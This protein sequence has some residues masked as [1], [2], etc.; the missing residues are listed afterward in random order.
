ME[1]EGSDEYIIFDAGTGLRDFGNHI[2]GQ[3]LRSSVFHIF[4]SHLHWDHIQGFPFFIPAFLKQNRIHIYGCHNGLKDA[5]VSQQSPPF[6]PVPFKVMNA[7]ID[8]SILTPLK[9]YEIAGIKVSAIEQNHPGGSYAYRVEKNGK[10]VV[11]AS[12]SE[13]KELGSSDN[14]FLDF[15]KG[16]DLLIFDA[17]YSL[18]DSLHTKENWGHSSNIAAVEV[19]L[20]AGVKHVCLFHS[21]PTCDDKTLDRVFE[22]TCKYKELFNEKAVLEISMAY[23]GKEIEV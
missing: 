3:P 20:Q 11:Y 23:D 2:M 13:Y 9:Q 12:D 15:I 6:F 4:I 16:A 10:S 5:F 8:F 21:E 18:L 17:Q 19:S 1:V 7:D 14:G 22:E